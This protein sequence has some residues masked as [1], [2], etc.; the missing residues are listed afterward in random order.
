MIESIVA[1][2]KEE[3][4]K[5]G[6]TT[7]ELNDKL[8]LGPGW[9]EGFEANQTAPTIDF[10]F[11][12]VRALDLDFETVFQEL[13]F[14]SA[15]DVLSHNI[16]VEDAKKAKQKGA[17]VRFRYNS[18]LAEVFIPSASKATFDVVV[19]KFRDDL[20]TGRKAEA[21]VDAYM[22]LVKLWPQANPSDIWWFIMSRL[23]SDPYFHPATEAHR[24]F[25][26]SWKRT[27]GWALEKIVVDHYREFL[28]KHKIEIGIF[29]RAEKEEL[30]K[31][32]RLNYHVE[33]NKADVL[34]L[35]VAGSKRACFGVAHVKASIAERRQN[36]QN[37]S[38]ALLSKNFFSPFV[39]MDCKSSPSTRPLNKGEFGITINKEGT[40][41]RRDK[42][43]EFE[44]EGY[45]SG[46]YSFNA[47][48]I[49]TPDGQMATSRIFVTDF[50]TAD[51][52]FSR[53][54]ISVRDKLFGR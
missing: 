34:L 51:D 12:I 19:E 54:A 24:D 35:N 20:S 13:D 53:A 11:A 2:L 38:A 18:Y 17:N 33:A 37:F 42:R 6:I 28:A 10:I 31:G 47:N 30:L 41:S 36:D 39:T 43:K 14:S 44:D 50:H 29:G 32:M 15:K 21:V 52:A 22:H 45:Y 8:R 48:T 27:A 46:C 40:D 16:E 26:Q 9:I 25:G 4:E 23:Y 7:D 3:R 5:A 49:P 1:K